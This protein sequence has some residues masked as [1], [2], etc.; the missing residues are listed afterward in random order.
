MFLDFRVRNA[1]AYPMTTRARSNPHP[2]AYE[3]RI[4]G[5][6]AAR[7]RRA[8]RLGGAAALRASERAAIGRTHA[9]LARDL[10]AGIAAARTQAAPG[11]PALAGLPRRVR[12]LAAVRAQAVAGLADT[13]E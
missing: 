8:A 6:V 2:A 11:T 10:V 3:T 13:P 12:A 7:G 5:S 4:D 9:G 1:Y